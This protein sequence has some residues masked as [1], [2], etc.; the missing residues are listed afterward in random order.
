M[1][2]TWLPQTP[3]PQQYAWQSRA[4]TRPK[5]VTSC[6]ALHINL[7]ARPP[8]TQQRAEIRARKEFFTTF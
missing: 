7:S 1:S 4:P 2:E 6:V 3:L 5:A 8:G